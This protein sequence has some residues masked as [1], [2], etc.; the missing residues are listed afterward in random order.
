MDK[1]R[2]LMIF[3]V[4]LIAVI[5][6]AV[7]YFWCLSASN[8]E[9][10]EQT[11]VVKLINKLNKK[12]LKDSSYLDYGCN[13]FDNRYDVFGES[14]LDVSDIT[15]KTPM[16]GYVF[17]E[18]V[19]VKNPILTS[20]SDSLIYAESGKMIKQ[21]TNYEF[22]FEDSEVSGVRYATNYSYKELDQGKNAYEIEYEIKFD[23]K[24]IKNPN[25]LNNIVNVKDYYDETLEEGEEYNWT[26]SIKKACEEINK[27]GGLL[28]FPYDN[29]LVTATKGAL[30]VIH[31]ESDKE[32]MVDF[33]NSKIKMTA[34][35]LGQYGVVDIKKCNNVTI[36]NGVL[37]GDRMV[38]DYSDPGFGQFRSTH[39]GGYGV[40]AGMVTNATIYNMEIY[41][42]TGDAV[43]FSNTSGMEKNEEGSLVYVGEPT[44]VNIDKCVLHHCRRQGVSVLDCKGF[45]ITNSEIYSIGQFSWAYEEDCDNEE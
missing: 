23:E 45:N 16:F 24:F 8:I 38:H 30:D 31:L 3:C 22:Y 44:T 6:V 12:L 40:E 11:Q 28:L 19:V 26:Q 13:Y 32:I 29:Y 18:D 21:I 17:V 2:I 37:Q 36:K 34:N 10:N 25:Y 33:C 42:F 9:V 7:V 5:L 35:N 39:E 20:F 4:P 14:E 43:C 15:Y 41:D 1:R 27:T